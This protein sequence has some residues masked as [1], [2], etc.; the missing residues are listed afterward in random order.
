MSS[1]RA[2]AIPMS[3]SPHVAPRR[4]TAYQWGQ[5]SLALTLVGGLLALAA[6]NISLRAGWHELEDGVLWSTRPEGTVAVEVASRGA[7]AVA[8]L[9]R[10]DLLLAIDGRPVESPQT[11]LDLVRG[12][13]EGSRLVHDSQA[14]R[15]AGALHRGAAGA[16]RPAST[17]LRPGSGCDLHAPGRC[18]RPGEPPGRP[19]HAA[20]LLAVHGLLRRLC[21]LVQRPARQARLGVLLGRRGGDAPAAATVPPLC[22]GVSGSPAR[23]G[24]HARRSGRCSRSS[25]RRRGCS[26]RPGPG[27]R[28]SLGEGAGSPR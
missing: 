28:R 6:A 1:S 17:L 21:V 14:G 11:V 10:G 8:G 15:P 23:L 16:W 3:V 19:R 13:Q 9:E 22:P 5:H 4:T 2:A 12:A 20:L 27:A 24:P 26:E 18:R 25:T 7:A